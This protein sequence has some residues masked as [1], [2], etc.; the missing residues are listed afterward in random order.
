MPDQGGARGRAETWRPYSAANWRPTLA[1]PGSFAGFL[2]RLGHCLRAWALA[3]IGAGRLVPWLA[4]GFGTGIV[5]Y[6]TADREPAIWA[7]VLVACVAI[8]VALPARRRPIGF[9]LALAIA[10]VAAGF[11]TATLKRAIIAHPVVQ[12]PAW[13]VEIAGF[14]ETREERERSDRIVV[15]VNASRAS[16]LRTSPSACAFRCARE[17]RPRSAASCSSKPAL[18]LRS[19]RSVPAATILPATCISTGSGHPVLCSV[20]SR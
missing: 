18:R 7:A 20:G 10:V 19:S 5:L 8:A 3:E 2:R 9:P 14:V 15:L 4:I 11:A 12:S 13:N 1:W 16:G 6:F 17:R